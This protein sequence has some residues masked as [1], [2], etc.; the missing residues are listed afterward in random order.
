MNERECFL[1]SI[2]LRLVASYGSEPP[3]RATDVYVSA[4]AW[5][6]RDVNPGDMV[7]CITSSMFHH[8]HLWTVAEVV[9]IPDDLIN[10]YF[11]LRDVITGEI[12]NMGNERFYRLVG[13]KAPAQEIK[14]E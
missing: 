3:P 11:G 13:I 5:D 8:Y 7:V 14:P 1:L 4:G 12:V 10:G 6:N 9:D 2:I